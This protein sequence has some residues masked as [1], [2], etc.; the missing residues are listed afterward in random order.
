MERLRALCALGDDEL[1]REIRKIA[2]THGLNLPEA[3]P[4]HA[5]M[6]RLRAAVSGGGGLNLASAMRIVNEYK[7]GKR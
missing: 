4:Q 3:T 5:E 7:R 1:W 6:E 2:G